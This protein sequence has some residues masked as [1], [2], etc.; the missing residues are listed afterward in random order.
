MSTKLTYTKTTN[1]ALDCTSFSSVTGFTTKGTIPNGCAVRTLFSV[2]SGATWNKLTIASG[3]ATFTAAATQAIT[4]ASVISEGN[5]PAELA[6]VT[7][8]AEMAGK[9]VYIAIAMQSSGTSVPTF[10][11]II[12]GIVGVMVY[13]KTVESD[14]II[15]YESMNIYDYDLSTATANG[16]TVTV[17]AALYQSNDGGTTYAWGDYAALESAKGK[18]AK[19]IKFKAVYNSPTVGTSTASINHLYVYTKLANSIIIGTD[20]DVISVTQD[21]ETEMMYCRLLVKHQKLVDAKLKAYVS[22]TAATKKRDKYVL[23]TGTGV[24]QTITLT[25]T[26][27]DFPRMVLYANTSQIASFDYNSIDNT[28][29][30]TADKDATIFGS[31]TYGQ[32]A[33][34]WQEMTFGST[35]KYTSGNNT[36]LYSST[37]TYTSEGV[38]KGVSAIRIGLE[39]PSGSVTDVAI[40]IGTGRTQLIY[41]DHYFRNDTLSFTAG[42]VTVLPQNW[43]YDDKNRLLSIACTKDAQIKMN[44]VYDAETPI[45]KGF[46]AAWNQ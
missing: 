29:T 3:V 17:T 12:N 37:Y 25:D 31:Y 26:G 19:G 35:Q 15:F 36:D 18:E 44:G 33:E 43:T 21:F 39:K 1:G 20:A 4:A 42:G 16:G 11:L 41:L 6:T 5:T 14:P 40:G 32:E 13:T 30:F 7:S 28:V 22:M 10:G 24:A 45:L 46:V 23:G 34:S 8:C 27:I 2:D 38:S 9:I